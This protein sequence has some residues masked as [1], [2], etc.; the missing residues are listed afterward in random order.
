MTRDRAGAID[1]AAVFLVKIR[2]NPPKVYGGGGGG[3][4][5]LRAV[6]NRETAQDPPDVEITRL[7]GRERAFRTNRFFTSAK[8]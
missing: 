5:A 1:P 6:F 2:R 3:G 8:V 7:A 4:E